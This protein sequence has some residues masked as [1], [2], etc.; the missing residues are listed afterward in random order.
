LHGHIFER[1]FR[2][3]ERTRHEGSGL[4]LFLSRQLA[5]AQGGSLTL[6]RSAPG[7]G[8][9]FV[10]SLPGVSAADVVGKAMP[11]TATRERARTSQR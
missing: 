6:R 7:A 8:S 9:T 5:E 10:L 4:G 1:Y 3:T 2:A 11:T